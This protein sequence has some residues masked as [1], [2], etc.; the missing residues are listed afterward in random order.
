MSSY[1]FDV[2]KR[3]NNE[4]EFKKWFSSKF[5]FDEGKYKRY[6]DQTVKNLKDG[7]CAT[8]YWKQIGNNIN[9]WNTAF[10]IEKGVQLVSKP[11]APEVVVKSLNSLLN[12]VYR[13]NILRNDRFPE[14][15]EEGWISPSNWFDKI[16]DIVRTTFEVKYLDGVKFF[17]E[18]MCTLAK[19]LS[20][21]F[22]CSY[23]ARDEGYYAAHASVK[24]PLPLLLPDWTTEEHVIEVEMQITTEFQ[25]M[26]KSLLHRYYEE[27]RSKLEK[28]DYKWQWDYHSDQFVPNYLG[29]IAHYLEGMIV[30]IRDKNK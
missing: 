3:P 13:K 6:Y 30:E 25:E 21:P 8:D 24:I 9:E 2:N 27:N 1:K 17:E 15:P 19:G 20:C 16:H 4:E 10:L 11:T 7:F 5:D 28:G 23:E 18:R 14:E 12:K 22:N 26:I 29:H